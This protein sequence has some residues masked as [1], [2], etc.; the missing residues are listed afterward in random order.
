MRRITSIC[1]LL[2]LCLIGQGLSASLG[3]A[4]ATP[5]DLLGATRPDVPDYAAVGD[6]CQAE[7]DRTQARTAAISDLKIVRCGLFTSAQANQPS[8]SPS[9]LELVLLAAA[10][11]IVFRFIRG[12]RRGPPRSKPSQRQGDYDSRPYEDLW[13]TL[14]SQK[15]KGKDGKPNLEPDPEESE[16]VQ[17]AKATFSRLREA[18]DDRDLEDIRQF[19]TPDMFARF[20][21]WA[22][23][24]PE[25][26]RTEI[27]LLNASLMG[28][29]K[30]EDREVA[31][32]SFDALVHSG[33]GSSPENLRQVWEFVR[34]TEGEGSTWLLDS[35][36]DVEQEPMQ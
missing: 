25:P 22:E 15:K 32:V 20:Q 27:M 31:S 34:S 7:P 29:R 36:E 9:F 2:V 33:G 14:R 4:L 23:R 11:I 18:W 17:G 6:D 10:L 28:V 1:L 26:K 3:A 21:E 16:F 12:G 24:N 8:R 13:D 35:L 5:S 19:T 30:E